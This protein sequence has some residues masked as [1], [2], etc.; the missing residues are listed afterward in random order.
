MTSKMV[1]LALFVCGFMGLALAIVAQRQMI[2]KINLRR[3][4]Q[5]QWPLFWWE[6]KPSNW[7]PNIFCVHEQYRQMYGDYG[8][9]RRCTLAW[10]YVSYSGQWIFCSRSGSP[11]YQTHP[12]GEPNFLAIF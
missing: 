6:A 8:L 3:P 11:D 12:T 9:P 5:Q 1:D 10:S 7:R 2:Q 4:P